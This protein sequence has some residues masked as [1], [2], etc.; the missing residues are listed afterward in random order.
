MSME[1]AL[2][3]VAGF[4]GALTEQYQLT[5]VTKFVAAKFA[6]KGV[7]LVKGNKAAGIKATTF[8]EL[9]EGLFAKG[10]TKDELKLVQREY[11]SQRSTYYQ[12]VK[13][14]IAAI[15]TDPRFRASMKVWRTPKTGKLCVN[16][17]FREAPEATE[18]NKLMLR[19][20]ELERQLKGLPAPAKS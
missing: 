16:A 4:N 20:A 14:V 18:T 17:S 19:I 12:Q 2:P 1:L 6:D 11:D 8:K 5:G 3:S 7:V 10:V 13:P 9:K 15:A